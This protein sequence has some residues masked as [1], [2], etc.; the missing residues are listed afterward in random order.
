MAW[1]RWLPCVPDWPNHSIVRHTFYE[2]FLHLHQIL[3]ATTVVGIL[4]HSEILVLPQRPFLYGVIST[5][6]VERF[7][8]LCR[9]FHHPWNYSPK[10]KHSKAAL[11]TWRSKS[12][13]PGGNPQV[14][15]YAYIPPLPLWMSHPFSVAWV[16][17][18]TR[19]PT[20]LERLDP[21]QTLTSS[22][23]SHNELFL[24]PN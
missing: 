2:M 21:G 3:A 7:I 1:Y 8:R 15:I 22:G 12:E 14:Y 20:R 6:G 11:A 17:R 24:I 23:P 9:I 13:E 4:L 10:S 19:K 16:D 18:P 5:W